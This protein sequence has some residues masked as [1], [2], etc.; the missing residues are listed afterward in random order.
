MTKPDPPRG[1][2]AAAWDTGEWD[3][4][5]M[6][7]QMPGLDGPSA[8]MRIR[9]CEPALCRTRTPIIALT[10]HAMS[11]QV[12]ECLASGMDGFVAKPI[13]I[14]RLFAALQAALDKDG[15]EQH[16]VAA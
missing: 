16:S 14:G 9:E 8:A 11:H 13:E 5:L 3:V 15:D 1:V 6:E 10:A 7:V 12:A 4:I 2:K